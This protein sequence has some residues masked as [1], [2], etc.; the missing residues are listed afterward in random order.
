M[1]HVLAKAN[2]LDVRIIHTWYHEQEAKQKNMLSILYK[3]LPYLLGFTIF[4]FK[5]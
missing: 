1:S 2:K 4:L 5:F 3:K